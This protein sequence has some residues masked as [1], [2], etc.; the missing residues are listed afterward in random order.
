[1]ANSQQWRIYADETG[2]LAGG[3][4]QVASLKGVVWK[5]NT[6]VFS[7]FASDVQN[8]YPYAYTFIEPNYGDVTNGDYENG[9]SQ[10]PMDSVIGGEGLIK[11]TY[12]AI[13]NSPLWDRSLLI[14]TYDEHGGFYDS[15]APGRPRRQT[16][17]ARRMHLDQ[18]RRLPVRPVRRA[19]AGG[20]R[21]AA[22]PP[23]HGRHQHSMTTPR[24]RPRCR[25]C[26]G[27]VD[28][29]ARHDRRHRRVAA[30]LSSPRTDCPTVLNNPA[31]G[32]ATAGAAPAAV[33][34]DAPLPEDRQRP[35]RLAD[36]GQDRHAVLARGDPAESAA[37][38]AR[39]AAIK[40]VGQAEAYAQEVSAKASLARAA[41]KAP[42]ARPDASVRP[43]MSP[44]NAIGPRRGFAGAR[45]D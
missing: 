21:F 7:D 5:Y 17:A 29:P 23:G 14:I 8:P 44:K 33:D 16:T 24:S 13:R 35:R 25:S 18:F 12:E 32:L 27:P 34:P 11:A 20:G 42:P 1:V 41:R 15:V 9:S 2:P 6:N 40:T 4:P 30:Q 39:V 26:T 22:D 45:T 38:Q 36:P 31:A 43:R 3:V 37:I 10:H 19:R 28:D